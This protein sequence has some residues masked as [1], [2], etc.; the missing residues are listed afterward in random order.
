MPPDIGE[1]KGMGYG[2]HN[3][4]HRVDDV[5]GLRSPEMGEH[6]EYPKDSYTADTENTGSHRSQ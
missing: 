5:E 2:R 1:E 3:P 4:G 6:C